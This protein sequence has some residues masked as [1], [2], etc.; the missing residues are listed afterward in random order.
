MCS[1]WRR[2]CHL[3]LSLFTARLPVQCTVWF[4]GPC[5][6]GVLFS[7][8]MG[9]VVSPKWEKDQKKCILFHNMV[10]LLTKSTCC[11]VFSILKILA[12]LIHAFYSTI[13]AFFSFIFSLSLLIMVKYLLCTSKMVN[14]SPGFWDICISNYPDIPCV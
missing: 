6:E 2:I 11:D 9:K 7:T 14:K 5:K 1:N 8:D 12:L 10:L 13:D 4:T 3:F